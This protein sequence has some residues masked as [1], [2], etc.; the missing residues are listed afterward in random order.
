M[1]AVKI[2]YLIVTSAVLYGN[3]DR[4]FLTTNGMAAKGIA[5]P[6]NGNQCHHLGKFFICE[7]Q[8]QF[9]QILSN[10]VNKF[11]AK[12]SKTTQTILPNTH[13]KKTGFCIL[14]ME[15]SFL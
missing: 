2:S 7:P 10:F 12:Q 9:P 15:T 13:I 14:L 6:R 1:Y 4:L 8:Y 3:T 11:T 5:L